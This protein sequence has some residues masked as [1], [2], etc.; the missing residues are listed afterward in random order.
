MPFLS[1]SHVRALQGAWNTGANQRTLPQLSSFVDRTDSWGMLLLDI[2]TIHSYSLNLLTLHLC[3]GSLMPVFFSFIKEVIFAAYEIIV[4][5]CI[6][7]YWYFLQ[8]AE[9]DF[10]NWRKLEVAQMTVRMSLRE[11]K[12][13][14]K[15]T[16]VWLPCLLCVHK[17]LK[18]L[19]ILLH[20]LLFSVLCKNDDTFV[21]Q[22][23]WSCRTCWYYFQFML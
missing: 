18:F 11:S 4:G 7:R 23:I 8:Q 6:I 1:S 5:A 19:W 10:D 17:L 15:Q 22:Q 16:Q 13:N 20:M 12:K 2:C 3:T 21:E 9:L 14:A